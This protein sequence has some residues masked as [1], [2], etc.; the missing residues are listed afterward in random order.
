MKWATRKGVRLDRSACVWLI[1]NFLD[2]DPEIAYLDAAELKGAAAS[3]AR[4]FHDTVSEDAATRERSSFQ[5]LLARSERTQRDPALAFMGQILH[6]AEMKEPDSVEE[7]EGLRA[8]AKGMSRLASSDQEMVQR[9]SV[10]FDALYAYC[11]DRVEGHYHWE[12]AEA[13]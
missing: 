9:M 1:R 10:V 7:A 3:G 2:S 12:N 13:S 11:K 8:I 6:G 5:E 4:V